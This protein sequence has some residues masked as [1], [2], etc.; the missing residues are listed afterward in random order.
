[1]DHVK[2]CRNLSIKAI[3]LEFPCHFCPGYFCGIDLRISGFH[4]SSSYSNPRLH[5]KRGSQTTFCPIYV[6]A[7]RWVD[8]ACHG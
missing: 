8:A 7:L 1:M 2:R 6:N 5:N 4:S 3:A